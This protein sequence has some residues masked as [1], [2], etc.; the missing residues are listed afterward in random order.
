MTEIVY[1]SRSTA[2]EFEHW[3]DQIINLRVTSL[4]LLKTPLFDFVI[5]ITFSFDWIFLKFADKVDMGGILD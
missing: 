5:S 1:H 2:L 4:S 3:P